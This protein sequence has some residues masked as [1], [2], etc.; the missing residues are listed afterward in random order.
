MERAKHPKSL[1]HFCLLQTLP[2]RSNC[3]SNR[4]RAERFECWM[5]CSTLV[6]PVAVSV[7]LAEQ[8]RQEA[9]KLA[10]WPARSPGE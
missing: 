1:E 9:A 4:T 10:S 2:I 7:S 5:V 8:G 3:D 6:V